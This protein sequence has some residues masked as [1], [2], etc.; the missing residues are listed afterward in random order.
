LRLLASCD[1][2]GSCD[3]RPRQALWPLH[4][5]MKRCRLRMLVSCHSSVGCKVAQSRICETFSMLGAQPPFYQADALSAAAWQRR[6]IVSP[7]L[8]VR[9]PKSTPA[10]LENLK[11]AAR[12]CA[13]IQYRGVATAASTRLGSPGAS[14]RAMGFLCCRFVVGPADGRNL[15]RPAWRQSLV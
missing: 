7:N 10:R 2:I 8:F 11:L 9:C 1:R 12:G 15:L 5:H 13:A 4:V 14:C 6:F 3:C